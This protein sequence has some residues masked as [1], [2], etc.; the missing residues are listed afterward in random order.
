MKKLLRYHKQGFP[1]EVSTELMNL[2]KRYDLKFKKNISSYI[3]LM[4]FK[5]G[6]YNKQQIEKTFERFRNTH[7]DMWENMEFNERNLLLMHELDPMKESLTQFTFEGSTIFIPFF[8][9]LMN[10]LYERET[11]ILELPQFFKLYSDFKASIIDMNVYGDLPLKHQMSDM[12]YITKQGNKMVVYYPKNRTFY[13]FEN[14]KV[15]VF[16]FY[17]KSSLTKGMQAV[18]AELIL[19][20]DDKAILDK[21]KYYKILS[22]KLM[23]RH[24]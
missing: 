11:A 23:R 17:I 20:G 7:L 8:D 14:N 10:N 5:E 9:V 24:K 22:P 4:I 6:L 16:P 2:N 19:S 18:M 12:E 21:A 15:Q 3:S 13:V 1:K